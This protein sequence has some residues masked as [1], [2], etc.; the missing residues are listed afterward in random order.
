M[1]QN[2]NFDI[3]Y[4]V[5][6]E[7]Y[8]AMRYAGEYFVEPLKE[9]AEKYPLE[10]KHLNKVHH[11]R[12]IIRDNLEALKTVGEKIY[13]GTLTYNEDKDQNKEDSK[14]KEAFTFLNS[15]FEFVLLVEEYGEVN[16]R[17][18]CHF[19]GT[20]RKDKGFEDF[21]KWHSRQNLQE[22]KTCD[23]TRTRSYFKKE[24]EASCNSEKKAVQYLCKYVSKQIPR[25]RRNK[26]LVRLEKAYKEH[27]PLKRTFRT[28]FNKVM[29]ENVSIISI[30]DL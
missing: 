30:F 14:R 10:Y 18:H 13:F 20:F 1:E 8:E 4:G 25:I 15:L 11:K 23:D 19:L 6:K 24:E 3:N 26:A 17:Y 29:K 22:L 28:T 16:G 7:Y 21:R 9:F 5:I 27:K 12:V 2:D